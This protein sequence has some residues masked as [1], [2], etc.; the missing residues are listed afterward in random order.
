MCTRLSCASRTVVVDSSAIEL[1]TATV[2]VGVETAVTADGSSAGGT[3][4]DAPLEATAIAR[5]DILS[6]EDSSRTS[7]DKA[8][9]TGASSGDADPP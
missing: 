5:A 6:V 2:L 1:S 8:A 3:D 9:G 7:T 4:G